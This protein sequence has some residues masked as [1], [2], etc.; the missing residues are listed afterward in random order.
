LFPA[1]ARSQDQPSPE[2]QEDNVDTSTLSR[3]ISLDGDVIT[4]NFDEMKDMTPEKKFQAMI[5]AGR[6]DWVPPYIT[7]KRFPVEGTGVRRFRPKLFLFG[8]GIF[9]KYAV[10]A[11]EDNKFKPGGH[12]HCFAYGA[13]C[14]DEQRKYPIAC[15][16][17]SAQV[18]GSRYVMYLDRCGAKGGLFLYDWGG[19]WIGSWHFLGVQEV[20]DA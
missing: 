17:S 15:L 16:G 4:I 6:Y 13:V 9:L 3:I 12:L 10:T 5:G 8:P 2:Q 7:A 19:R 20:S 18:L 14:P 11:V 1:V